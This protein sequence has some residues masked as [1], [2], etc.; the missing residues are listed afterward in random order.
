M[1]D[2]I[3]QVLSGADVDKVWTREVCDDVA[4]ELIA[5]FDQDGNG[6]LDF[7]EWLKLMRECANKRADD[8]EGGWQ[9][10]S[11]QERDLLAALEKPADREGGN[12]NELKKTYAVL[13][14][15]DRP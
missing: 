11:S 7:Q 1:G 15:A 3:M 9:S 12:F 14:R 10:R 13:E 5:R 8:S 6:S 4:T 2:E